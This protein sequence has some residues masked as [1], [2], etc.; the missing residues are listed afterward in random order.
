MHSPYC[1]FP[2]ASPFQLAQ[3]CLIWMS[4]L[5]GRW[6]PRSAVASG[7]DLSVVEANHMTDS[8]FHRVWHSRLPEEAKAALSGYNISPHPSD[9]RAFLYL[10]PTF[11]KRWAKLMH[12]SLPEDKRKP[13][14]LY[15]ELLEELLEAAMMCR[16]MEELPS[17]EQALHSHK[18]N[19]VDEGP[20]STSSEQMCYASWRPQ[21]SSSAQPQ[22]QKDLD[23][24]L[25]NK[26][27]DIIIGHIAPWWRAFTHL[28]EPKKDEEKYPLWRPL[29]GSARPATLKGIASTIKKIKLVMPQIFPA[30]E[31][32]VVSLLQ[33]LQEQ[34]C[35]AQFLAGAW[36]MLN[37]IGAHFGSMIPENHEALAFRYDFAKSNL[38]STAIVSS[39]AAVPPPLSC[40]K[41]LE[42]RACHSDTVVDKFAAAFFRWCVGA[43]PRFSD[44][45]HTRPDTMLL[46]DETLEFTA[47]Q[48]KT[49]AA[50]DATRPQPLIAPLI[51][52]TGEKWWLPLI[53]IMKLRIKD[54][55]AKTDDYMLPQPTS[56]R[57]AFLQ[58]PCGNAKALR[59]LRTLLTHSKVV[60]PT[61]V[62]RTMT[63]SGFRVFMPNLAFKYEL[64]RERRRYLGRWVQES[65]ADVYTREHRTVVTGIWN[66]VCDKMQKEMSVFEGDNR[67]IPG[68]CT[69]LEAVPENLTSPHYD[70][71]V[72]QPAD[73]VEPP[74]VPGLYEEIGQPLKRDPLDPETLAASDVGPVSLRVNNKRLNGTESF[75]FKVHWFTME[76]RAI[77]CGWRPKDVHRSTSPFSASEWKPQH[78]SFC[79]SCANAVKVPAQCDTGI[80]ESD[81]EKDAW[82][83]SDGSSSSE[84]D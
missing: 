48:T 68:V 60:V 37:W 6:T 46:T 82:V 14:E 47:W 77:G 41:A 22:N 81:S 29:V 30:N 25:R 42:E 17:W 75:V 32:K 64:A 69:P 70:L 21:G 54:D 19:R 62:I 13:I 28:V 67:D 3:A 80:P 76:G 74:P 79:K 31:Y 84:S 52:F 59:W 20:L 9:V 45:M 38:V 1:T 61:E 65:T 10:H 56:T 71:N 66:E 83:S 11:K 12:E 24:A 44:T 16:S 34:A 43:S 63:L 2:A 78:H 57:Q 73:E 5:L 49:K 8:A 23:Q 72:E 51:T 26:Y 15:N 53:H 33:K 36:K 50:G 55:D 58:K 39:R 7:A 27:A 18:K 35:T 4:R 40:V